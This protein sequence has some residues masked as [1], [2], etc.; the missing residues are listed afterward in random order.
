MKNIITLLLLLICIYAFPQTLC[1]QVTP[2]SPTLTNVGSY[3]NHND[4]VYIDFTGDPNYAGTVHF[5][6]LIYQ[7]GSSD[8]FY[9]G[10]RNVT[11]NH[12]HIPII[13]DGSS[14]QTYYFHCPLPPGYYIVTTRLATNPN[15]YCD[16]QVSGVPIDNC[17]G[18]N[19]ILQEQSIISTHYYNILGQPTEK[20]SG[21]VLIKEDIYSD[22]FSRF[23]KTLIP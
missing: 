5:Q 20:H 13:W 3:C 10:F 2:F 8:T 7:D 21:E 11:G 6:F 23:I 12:Q 1:P 22:G 9:T 16:F 15:D 14:S 4:T 17:T 18:I 19:D